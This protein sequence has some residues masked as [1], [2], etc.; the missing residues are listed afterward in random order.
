MNQ[1]PQSNTADF[2]ADSPKTSRERLLQEQKAVSALMKGNISALDTTESIETVS[3]HI[4][5]LYSQGNMRDSLIL[6]E[7]LGAWAQNDSPAYKERS[8]MALSLVTE[9]VLQQDN[10][11]FLEALSHLLVRWLQHE[12]DYLTCFEFICMQLQKMLHRMLELELWYQ[13]E[14]IVGVLHNVKRGVIKKNNILTQV[15]SR[16]HSN[17][18]GKPTLDQL[19]TT[20]I[21]EASDKREVAGTLLVHF[22]EKSATHLLKTLAV[23]PER[24]QRFQLIELIPSTGSEALVPLIETLQTK[25]PWYLVR[26]IILILSKLADP[27]LFHI[28]KPFMK[29]RDIRVQQEVVE[30]V[31]RMKGSKTTEQLLLALK[32]CNDTLKPHLIRLIGPTQEKRVESALLQLLKQSG[33]FAP[34]LRN[35]IIQE[36]CLQVHHHPKTQFIAPLQEI[37]S[38]EQSKQLI[39][40]KTLRTIRSTYLTLQHDCSTPVTIPPLVKVPTKD[41]LLSIDESDLTQV[42]DLADE[43]EASPAKQSPE[44]Q[45]A[46]AKKGDPETLD[47]H[48]LVQSLDEEIPLSIKEHLILREDFYSRLSKDEINAFISYLTPSQFAKGQI[49]T[50][51][52][53]VHSKLYFID[54]GKVAFEFP[55]RKNPLKTQ[56]LEKGDSFGH[57][58]F[59]TGSEWPVSLLAQTDCQLHIFDQE[60]LLNL[61]PRF[62]E[63]PFKL[64]DYCQKNEVLL[65]ILRMIDEQR[66][67]P[68]TPPLPF[69][70]NTGDHITNVEI[71][72][73][74]VNGFCFSLILPRGMDFELFLGKELTIFFLSGSD[75]KASVDA[76]IIGLE[77]RQSD[78][79]LYMLAQFIGQATLDGYRF[80][81]IT[82]AG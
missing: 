38:K 57:D 76:K 72:H 13:A 71:V 35:V 81:R 60:L 34:H 68:L 5:E 25:P 74:A 19:T 63:L 26:N 48:W 51:S 17:L 78:S 12:K 24:N 50:S 47:A 41:E 46:S 22:G 40:Q 56:A 65:T 39:S 27:S 9:K 21:N 6:L 43:Q 80:D 73:C 20:Y 55:D 2:A 15:I 16:V 44:I 77:Y 1:N 10:E 32:N 3:H 33:S 66:D 4:L 75:E 30:Y 67:K 82:L 36:I 7:N 59:M 79:T 29:H 8:L 53:D 54:S 23:C 37:F 28:I 61:Q 18:A 49:L 64:F 14:D 45:V 70:G 11:D 58:I 42:R 62:P 31:R 52:G 69:T